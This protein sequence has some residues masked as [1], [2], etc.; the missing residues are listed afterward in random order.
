MAHSR[1]WVHEREVV[2]YMKGPTVP[3][4]TGSTVLYK[5]AVVLIYSS[6]QACV[7][8]LILRS[9][10]FSRIPFAFGTL[11]ITPLGW[12]NCEKETSLPVRQQPAELQ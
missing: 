11:E 5:V 2:T 9:A 4:H 6:K 7:N 12:R 1:G 3:E 8:G 10:F